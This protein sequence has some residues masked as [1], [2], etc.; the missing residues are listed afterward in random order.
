MAEGDT[1]INALIGAVVGIVLSFVPFSTVLGG[2]VAGYLEGGDRADGLRVGA[3]AGV[4][5]LVPIFLFAMF[6]GGLFFAAGGM[7]LPPN[8]MG[9]SGAF[10]M[11]ALFF[12]LVIALVYTVGLAALGGFLGNYVKQ[13]TDIDL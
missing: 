4:V 12:G 11:V 2:A 9:A 13:D 8:A 3:F 10:A 1:A 6:F 5:M 7:M